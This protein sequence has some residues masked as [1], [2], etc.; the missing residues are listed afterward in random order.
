MKA[1]NI[2]LMMGIVLFAVSGCQN[3]ASSSSS[4]DSSASSSPS[5][6]EVIADTI[7][8]VTGLEDKTV[9]RN[10]YFNPL[11]GVKATSANGVDITAYLNVS[12]SVDYGTLGEYVLNYSL[13]YEGDHY[14]QTRTVSVTT[15]T[16][17][18][19]VTTKTASG[20]SRVNLDGGS[21]RT[22]VAGDLDHP[23]NP[24]FIEADL[25][26]TAV[27]SNGWWTS[28]LV[29]NYGGSNGIYTNPLKS[30]FKNEGVEITN[31]GSGFV[32]FW[33]PENNM[34]IAQFSLSFNDLLLKTTSLSTGYETKVI[35]YS[36]NGVKVAMRNV[37][38]YEDK[39]VITYAQGSPY[40]FAEVADKQTPYLNVS[41]A[42]VDAYEYYDLSGNL[43]TGSSYS[44]DA[45]I[46]KMVRRHV[47]YQCTPP[48][49]VGS[50]VYEDRFFLINAPTNSTF[51]LSKLSSP[52]NQLDHI[53][54]Q[55]G[56]GNYLSIAAIKNL[57]EAT[58][59][60]DHGYAFIAKANTSFDVD[61]EAGIVNTHYRDNIQRMR[62]DLSSD[63]ALFLMPHQYKK[64][65]I[66]LTDYSFTT[67]RGRLKAMVGNAFSTHL[68]FNGVL[69]GYT[70]PTN[71]AF[72]STNTVE[73]LADLDSRTETNDPSSFINHASPYFNSKAL[74]PLSQGLIIADQLNNATYKAKF[75]A[76]LEYL[77][78][79]WF[80]Y[81]AS[82]DDKYLY[83]NE[84]WGSVYYSDNEFNTASE[85]TDHSFTHGYLVYA[86][87]VLAMY[88]PDF[89][90]M[91]GKVI[92]VLLKD[93]M[94]A[95]RTDISSTYLRSFDSWAGHSWAHGF[96]TFAEGNN[97]ES[98]G[99]TLNSWVGGYLLAQQENNQQM[100]DAAIYG[101]V[102]ELYSAKQYWFDYDEDIWNS[103]YTYYAQ[104][105]GIVWGGKFDYAT[106]FGA[107]PTFI[108]GIQWLPSGEFLT[109]Y[110]IGDE[111]RS[112]LGEAYD[113]YLSAKGGEPDTWYSDMWVIQAIYDPD[114]ALTNF[115]ATKIITDDFPNELV[116]CYWAINALKT[117]N[118]HTD[119]VWMEI[120]NDASSSVY[121]DI[122][123]NYYAMIWNTSVQ[124]K[125]VTF[126]T[127]DGVLTEKTV[128]G[129]SFTKVAL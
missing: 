108:Y 40:I 125:T 30:S 45:L 64:T 55:L 87:A 102:T 38:N 16:Y 2:A 68:S 10:H 84:K 24:T 63:S 112:N 34:T 59:Y 123:G 8:E 119:E 29:A 42:G 83:Y 82:G 36:D 28:L 49:V 91:Y 60:H 115:D 47:G 72:S 51:T 127:T 80:T 95:D 74:F 11:K 54:M 62:S 39:M 12:G 90:S 101:Y 117:L 88:D 111:E 61:H 114:A 76:K 50:A 18:P 66:P 124:E 116:G 97:Q 25:L 73:Y 13:D 67:V 128:A 70:T 77:L 94:N 109:S 92:N 31:P 57:D 7:G 27:T 71:L 105:V 69:P 1:K 4:L 41:T 22:G 98:I 9:I 96:G 75:I 14:A 78:S 37:G 20:L 81:T 43:I 93:Y 126:R 122:N 56:D 58:F 48:A 86:S 17:T 26:D 52:N 106:W 65:S 3:T 104:T 113:K 85:L 21:Y 99:E 110:A 89:Y 19:P 44:G 118:V 32:Q 35:D 53:A 121:K 6:S 15:G 107:N 46:L 129:R 103:Q 100:V 79:D 5:S 33:N 23:V 120:E